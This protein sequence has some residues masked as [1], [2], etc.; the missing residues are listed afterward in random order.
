METY[1][2]DEYYPDDD[3][4]KLRISWD[5]PLHKFLMSTIVPKSKGRCRDDSPDN[6][7]VCTREEGHDGPHVGCSSSE[8]VGI[9]HNGEDRDPVHVVE[10]VEGDTYDPMGWLVEDEQQD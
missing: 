3:D 5:G 10:V 7:W 2:F 8:V 1:K 6:H 9:W 4:L